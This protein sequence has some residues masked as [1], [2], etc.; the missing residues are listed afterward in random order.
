MAQPVLS[1]ILSNNMP[2]AILHPVLK[3]CGGAKTLTEIAVSVSTRLKMT[4]EQTSLLYQ[5]LKHHEKTFL[6]LLGMHEKHR[7]ARNDPYQAIL[8]HVH[9]QSIITASQRKS[10]YINITQAEPT[11]VAILVTTPES[12]MVF[13]ETLWPLLKACSPETVYL[14][15]PPETPAEKYFGGQ[16]QII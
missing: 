12:A 1:E 2:Y 15:L 14:I 4:D 13:M 6:Q 11:N 10:E 5:F 16:F 7:R 3:A 8:H 9:V